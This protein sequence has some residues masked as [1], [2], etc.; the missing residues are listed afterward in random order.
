MRLEPGDIQDLR[1][2]IAEVVRQTLAQMH[3]NDSRVP[4]DRLGYSEPESAA[5][6]GLERHQLRDMRLRGEI[7]AKKCGKEYR[8]SRQTLID[9]LNRP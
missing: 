3:D 5:L 4:A 1:P 6:L 7:H 9:F 2:V 8:Y